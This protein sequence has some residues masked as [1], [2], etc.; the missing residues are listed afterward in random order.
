MSNRIWLRTA[1]FANGCGHAVGSS[2]S[3]LEYSDISDLKSK[4]ISHNVKH[5]R[6]YDAMLP[7]WYPVEEI[8]DRLVRMCQRDGMSLSFN[9]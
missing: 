7:G 1:I 6:P 3:T 9:D 4:L 2:M 5:V 8:D